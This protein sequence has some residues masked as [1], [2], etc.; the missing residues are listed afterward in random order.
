MVA[1]PIHCFYGA[2]S[3]KLKRLDVGQYMKA[4]K[5]LVK[6]AIRIINEG[7]ELDELQ[8]QSR[9]IP[10]VTGFRRFNKFK[11]DVNQLEDDL[12]FVEACAKKGATSFFY[13]I[14]MILG[15]TISY[16]YIYLY[17]LKDR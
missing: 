10:N 15:G 13:V 16:I 7:Q 9:W 1:L 12:A 8:R 6:E 14:G 5:I 4:K 11:K 3:R 2:F 17:I